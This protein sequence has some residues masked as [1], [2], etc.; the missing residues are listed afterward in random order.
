MDTTLRQAVPLQLVGV[1]GAGDQGQLQEEVRVEVV[2]TYF[3][4]NETPL[5]KPKS[6]ARATT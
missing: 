3:E 4:D 2:E 6:G 1:H 5:A